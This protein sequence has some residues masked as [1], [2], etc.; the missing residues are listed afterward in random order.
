MDKC[1]FFEELEQVFDQLKSFKEE[2]EL[3]NETL[4]YWRQWWFDQQKI[5]EKF[6]MDRRERIRVM[7]LHKS[8]SRIFDPQ[9]E[10]QRVYDVFED[11]PE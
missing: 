6:S 8:S 5:P 9:K 2:N 11:N 3:L 7:F 4:F 10:L 1:E